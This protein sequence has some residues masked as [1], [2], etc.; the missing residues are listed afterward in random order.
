MG[1]AMWFPGLG[2]N[3]KY[4][5]LSEVDWENSTSVGMWGIYVAQFLLIVLLITNVMCIVRWFRH[6]NDSSFEL[7]PCI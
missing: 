5:F 7:C 2:N 6:R 4:D 1:D 3:G